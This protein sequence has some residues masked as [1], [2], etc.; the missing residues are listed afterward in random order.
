MEVSVKSQPAVF[1]VSA[2]CSPRWNAIAGSVLAAV[3]AADRKTPASLMTDIGNL[4]SE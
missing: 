1:Q 3:T 2:I 4:R